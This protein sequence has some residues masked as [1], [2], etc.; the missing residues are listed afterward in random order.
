M[1][2]LLKRTLDKF[3]FFKLTQIFIVLLLFLLITHNLYEFY[4]KPTPP[5]ISFNRDVINLFF[6]AYNIF[7]IQGVCLDRRFH[8]SLDEEAAEKH[9]PWYL[10]QASGGREGEKRQLRT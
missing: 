6:D 9:C 1:Y 3:F 2:F 4:Q 8:H 7:L 10:H 5:F